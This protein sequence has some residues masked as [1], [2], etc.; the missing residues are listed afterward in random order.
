MR[1]LR[2]GVF[3]A[4]VFTTTVM[5][6]LST[7]TSLVTIEKPHPVFQ[8]YEASWPFKIADW[9]IALG[10]LACCGILGSLVMAGLFRKNKYIILVSTTLI[11]AGHAWVA[12]SIWNSYHYATG[13]STYPLIFLL[14]M[15]VFWMTSTESPHEIS[16]TFI[17]YSR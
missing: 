13:A 8:W 7:I 15:W 4:H 10:I 9:A 1:L 3:V 2:D 6:G 16:E 17:S 12:Q 14:S 5:C 11:A